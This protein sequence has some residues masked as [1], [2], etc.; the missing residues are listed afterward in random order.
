MVTNNDIT[1]VRPL[2]LTSET[3][4]GLLSPSLHILSGSQ[5]KHQRSLLRHAQQVTLAVRDIPK[6]W[7][8]KFGIYKI[9]VSKIDT[10]ENQGIAGMV[11]MG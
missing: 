1:C 9:L 3:W 8:G 7:D 6:F 2:E 10:R 11:G 4:Q 5:A